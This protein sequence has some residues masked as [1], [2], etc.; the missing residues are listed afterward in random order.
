[1]SLLLSQ[2]HLPST[3]QIK[4]KEKLNIQ[5]VIWTVITIAIARDLKHSLFRL[6]KEWNKH[7]CVWLLF[8]FNFNTILQTSLQY[9]KPWVSLVLLCFCLTRRSSSQLLYRGS[10]STSVE[11]HFD[12]LGWRWVRH[13]TYPLLPLTAPWGHWLTALMTWLC[14]FYAFHWKLSCKMAINYSK[15]SCF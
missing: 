10:G 2:L 9:F 7:A 4:R 6:S 8:L 3:N 13:H 1:M 14:L 12:P 11:W 15:A 5:I